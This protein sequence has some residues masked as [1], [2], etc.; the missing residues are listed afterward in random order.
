MT[1]C[2]AV[3]KSFV[4]LEG[5]REYMRENMIS[6]YRE[7]FKDAAEDTTPKRGSTAYYAVAHVLIPGIEP[8][9]QYEPLSKSNY[10]IS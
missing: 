2:Q 5:A 8:V 9:W 1:G 4:K 6:E 7:V 10:T 3:H